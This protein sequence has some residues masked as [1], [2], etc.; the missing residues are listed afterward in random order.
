MGSGCKATTRLILPASSRLRNAS[1]SSST[2]RLTKNLRVCRRIGPILLI[3]STRASSN[4]IGSM[5]PCIL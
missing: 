3:S 2:G 5:T 1:A 4:G